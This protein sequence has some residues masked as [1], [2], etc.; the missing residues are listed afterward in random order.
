M[1]N[2]FVNPSIISINPSQYCNSQKTTNCYS[3]IFE[4]DKKILIPGDSPSFL[5]KIW[6]SRISKQIQILLLGHHGSSTS[7]SDY[8]LQKLSHINIA[9][10]SARRKKYG[11]PTLKIQSKL[12]QY[13]IPLLSTEEWGSIIIEL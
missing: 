10:S 9:I 6:L 8:L 11:H 13:F 2:S 3:R 4:W 5:E 7:T 12:K 1:C